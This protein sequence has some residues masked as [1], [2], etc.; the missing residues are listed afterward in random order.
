MK[1]C[2]VSIIGRPNVGKST[3]L[4]NILDYD[5]SIV[6]S[7]KHT[8]RDLINGIYNDGEFQIIFTD[9]PG[10]HKAIN[11][12]G[13]KLNKNSFNSLEG[14]DLILFLSPINEDIGN[15]DLMIIE[16]IKNFK[17]KLAIITK[18]DL[19]LDREILNKRAAQL[20]ELGFLNVLGVSYEYK[21]TVIDLIEEIKTYSYESNLFYEEDQITDKSMSFIVKEV[22]R[23]AAINNL[24][25]EVPHSIA[26]VIN[27]FVE[28]EDQPYEIDATIYVAKES[29][30]GILI[31]KNGTMIKKIGKTA[32]YKLMEQFDHKIILNI[33]IKVNKN[34]VKEEKQ[35]KLLG[36]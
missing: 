5:L 20:K 8:T 4:N 36:Y 27:S 22:I 9:T 12:F 32:R 33:K 21:Q 11:K 18:V 2:F 19:E 23:E 24:D 16:K 17:N 1:T 29:Q 15:S 3:L 26:V 6:T 25:H 7:K 31:G 14:V 30:K 13:E 28:S 10:I 34:W 35:I